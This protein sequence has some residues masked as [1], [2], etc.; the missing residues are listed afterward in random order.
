MPDLPADPTNELRFGMGG[1]LVVMSDG[2]F[3]SMSADGNILEIGPVKEYLES[4]AE[5]PPEKMV[6]GLKIILEK[7]Q[8]TDMPID[9]QT[10]IIIKKD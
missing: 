4:V 5:H 9:D 7:W 8:N 3:E 1:I 6:E 10:L 2:I